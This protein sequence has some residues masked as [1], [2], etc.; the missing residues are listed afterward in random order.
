MGAR[1][2]SDSRRPGALAQRTAPLPARRRH[3]AGRPLEAPR[4]LRP[5]PRRGPRRAPAGPRRTRQP[6][7]SDDG[8]PGGQS[9]V[10]R[11]A[12][13]D[14]VRR[15]RSRHCSTGREPAGRRARG[16]GQRTPGN[17]PRQRPD[18]P[19]EARESR[20]R[21]G[22]RRL[23]PDQG[24]RAR[25]QGL[26]RRGQLPQPV[27]HGSHC[28]YAGKRR[29]EPR[30]RCPYAARR[31]RRDPARPRLAPPRRHHHRVHRRPFPSPS[32]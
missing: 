27:R 15:R 1:A 28:T 26:G 21:T 16:T 7:P 18:P 25:P 17:G 2:P 22:A 12:V 14:R 8:G 3:R 19:R 23:R 24:R 4:Q 30:T 13:G 32:G 10:P 6:V 9:D 29:R 20:R 5:R 11:Q 31:R